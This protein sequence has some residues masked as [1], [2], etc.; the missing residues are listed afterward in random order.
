[1]R[2]ASLVAHAAVQA[3]ATVLVP[4]YALAAANNALPAIHRAPSSSDTDA[5][6]AKERP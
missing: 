1:M 3:V 6:V 5:A 2:K 4:L